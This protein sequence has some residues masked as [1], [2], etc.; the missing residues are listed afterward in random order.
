MKLL[1]EGPPTS[2][3]ASFQVATTSSRASL[4][5]NATSRNWHKMLY[6]YCFIIVVFVLAVVVVPLGGFSSLC[7]ILVHRLLIR[8]GTVVFL[9]HARKAGHVPERRDTSNES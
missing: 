2:P 9:V 3:H 8:D 5:N 1:V 4:K 6:C 7:R